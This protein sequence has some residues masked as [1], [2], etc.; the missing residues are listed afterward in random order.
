[1]SKG[2]ILHSA[3]EVTGGDDVVT[4]SLAVSSSMAPRFTIV[5]YATTSDGEVLADALTV[6]VQVFGK[7]DVSCV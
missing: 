7:M 1:M 2:M 5:V 6:P 3:T 4:M